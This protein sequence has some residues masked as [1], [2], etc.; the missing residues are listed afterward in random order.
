MDPLYFR[1]WDRLTVVARYHSHSDLQRSDGLY[2]GFVVHKPIMDGITELE[3]YS[4]DQEQLLLVGDW[5]HLSAA[6][7]QGT[8]L[9]YLSQ[10]N[11]VICLLCNYFHNALKL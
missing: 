7:V 11:E 2:G 10:G 5:Y 8:Y 9:T 3:S 4:Y 6:E 1:S